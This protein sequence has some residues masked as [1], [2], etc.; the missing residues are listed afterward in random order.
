M[1]LTIG[2]LCDSLCITNIKI[3]F[4]ENIKRDESSDDKAVADATRRTND[5]NVTRNSLISE[6]DVAL[7]KIAEG[8][9]QQIFYAHKLYGK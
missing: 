1:E 8:K 3:F 7:N 9:K 5:L 2:Q 6:I 4:L